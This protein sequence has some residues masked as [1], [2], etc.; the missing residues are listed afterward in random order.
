MPDLATLHPRGGQ[1]A[2]LLDRLDQATPT[3]GPHAPWRALRLSRG[4]Q[5]VQLIG[6]MKILA[7]RDGITL[8]Q[9]WF[10][11]RLVF[12]WENQRATVPGFYARLLHQVYT[13]AT[14]RRAG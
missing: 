3:T 10:L 14:A 1:L 6:R 5:P 13:T 9:T 2:A 11:I 12:L 8:P 7:G 4:W